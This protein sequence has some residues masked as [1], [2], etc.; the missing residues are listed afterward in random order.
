M[1]DIHIIWEG[2]FSLE[3]SLN[4]NCESDYGLYQFYGDHI[5]YG[6]NVLLYLGKTESQTFGRRISQHNWNV[7][8]SSPA[9][10]YLGKIVSESPLDGEEWNKQI[11]L[12]ERIILQS[13]T[14]TFNSSNLNSIGHKDGDA[15]V[16]NWGMR[17]HILPEIS[18]SR[19]EGDYAVGNKVKDRFKV[20]RR[21]QTLA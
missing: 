20:Q 15:R 8:T 9:Q 16:L 19:W 17:K 3:E 18:I 11:C 13:H 21:G 5:V 6:Q 14:P 7:W 2:P 1:L 4:K 12:A 10:I